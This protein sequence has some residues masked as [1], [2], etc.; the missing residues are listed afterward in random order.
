MISGKKLND[1]I[2]LAIVEGARGVEE[3]EN[4]GVSPAL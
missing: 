3:V 1:D 4:K 2:R